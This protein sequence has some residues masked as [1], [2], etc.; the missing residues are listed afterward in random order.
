MYSQI[1]GAR[2]ENSE[3]PRGN[4]VAAGKTAIALRGEI[5]MDSGG[6]GVLAGAT[7]RSAA[8]PDLPMAGVSLVNR[9]GYFARKST[10]G[11]IEA[12]ATWHLD[13]WA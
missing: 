2:R 1:D 7:I 13:D 11:P 10:R 3:G 9:A 4:Q 6:S 8:D 5:Q 12:P